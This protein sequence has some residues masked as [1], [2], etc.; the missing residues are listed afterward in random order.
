MSDQLS[1]AKVTAGQVLHGI[2]ITSGIV[3]VFAA[4]VIYQRM[5]TAEENIDKLVLSVE[6]LAKVVETVQVDWAPRGGTITTLVGQVADL[7]RQV[8]VFQGLA[9]ERGAK[10]DEI[11]RRLDALEDRGPR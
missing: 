2:S 6:R 7:Q 5:A 11:F 3:A 4:G 9:A 8:G 1:A 10:F